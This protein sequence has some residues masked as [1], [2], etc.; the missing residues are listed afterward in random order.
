ME[1]PGWTPIE[2]PD[3]RR[4]ALIDI[5]GMVHAAQYNHT[6]EE[7]KRMFESLSAGVALS[8]LAAK[9]F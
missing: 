4:V 5:D 1:N 2:I 3:E 6:V 9:Y 8:R 7:A